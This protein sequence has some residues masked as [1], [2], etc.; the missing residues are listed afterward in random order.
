MAAASRYA[1]SDTGGGPITSTL[2]NWLAGAGIAILYASSW[3]RERRLRA[4]L[5]PSLVSGLAM[6]AITGRLRGP[7]VYRDSLAIAVLGLFGGF[8]TPIAL[9][10]GEDRPIPLFTYLFLLDVALLF[11]AHK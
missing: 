10:T 8:L 11:L 3:A 6:V 9:S 1:D 4:H 5:V 7:C 2:A